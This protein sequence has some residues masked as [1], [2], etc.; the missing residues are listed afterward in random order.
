MRSKLAL[1]KLSNDDVVKMEKARSAKEGELV[2]PIWVKAPFLVLCFVL[3]VLYEVCDCII[4]ACL[5]RLQVAS[6]ISLISSSF[7]ST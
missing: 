5:D 2:T 7:P 4:D 1:L 6:Q 3:D